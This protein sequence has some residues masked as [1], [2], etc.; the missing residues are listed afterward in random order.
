MPT[1]PWSKLLSGLIGSFIVLGCVAATKA[2]ATAPPTLCYAFLK[3]NAYQAS[4]LYV[5]CGAQDERITKLGDIWDF[6]VATDGSVLALRRQRGTEKGKDGYGRPTDI[7]HFEM[8][9][10]SLKPGFERHWSPVDGDASLYP[11][12]G[13]ILAIAQEVHVASEKP[14]YE[15][16]RTD[17]VLTGK[18]V[19]LPPY[20]AFGC[21]SDGKTVV[22]Y[23][24]GDRRALWA[25]LPPRRRIAR[26]ETQ[27]SI[28]TYGVSP[29]GQYVAYTT[30]QSLCADKNGENLGCVRGSSAKISVSDRGG[31]LYDSG[32]GETCAGWECT[33]VFYWP[34]GTTEAKPIEPVGWR[35]QWITPEVAA[36]LRA[37]RS[38]EYAPNGKSRN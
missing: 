28:V 18:P 31:V 26:E 20:V 23:L 27:Y 11:Y 25:G 21:S 36:A 2:Q 29:D 33:G 8:E 10:I 5:T 22:G 19:T 35:A 3:G 1:I 7:P 14:A 17:N 16:Y 9:V 34:A 15:T 38:H 30:L 4:D 6:A 24:E 13:S 32:T 37:W 12:C